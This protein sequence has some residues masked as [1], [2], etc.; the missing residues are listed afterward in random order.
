MNKNPQLTS[1]KLIWTAFTKLLRSLVDQHRSVEV[2]FLGKFVNKDG[3]AMF[4]PA[5]EFVTAGHF[6]LEENLQNVSPL[7][8][9]AQRFAGSQV[10]SLTSV[11][12]SCGTDREQT[13]QWIKRILTEFIKV[14]RNGCLAELQ[15]GCGSLIAYPNGSL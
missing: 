12:A 13:A 10:I 9:L 7:S 5:L 11:S 1:V 8:K 14:A 3:Q 2:P 15:L 4:M 6:R